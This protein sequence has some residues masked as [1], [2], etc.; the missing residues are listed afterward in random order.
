MGIDRISDFVKLRIGESDPF[1]DSLAYVPR[2]EI[3][4][5]VRLDVATDFEL[6]CRPE[7]WRQQE[8]KY[9][10]ERSQSNPGVSFVGGHAT[11]HS[12]VF[13]VCRAV[14]SKGLTACSTIS[15]VIP[16]QKPQL[17]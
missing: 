7:L 16:I 11:L 4:H 13:S 14:R 5:L 12:G 3:R 9:Q 8:N 10:C 15:S 6:T 17:Y 1:D 2:E